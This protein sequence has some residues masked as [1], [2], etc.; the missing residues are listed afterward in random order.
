M[1]SN[2]LSLAAAALAA[3][4]GAPLAAGAAELPSFSCGAP[5]AA[6]TWSSGFSSQPTF[7][8]TVTG[9]SGD[10][11]CFGADFLQVIPRKS[12]EGQKDFLKITLAEAFVDDGE[13]ANAEIKFDHKVFHKLVDIP[14]A[15]GG[16]ETYFDLTQFVFNS[17]GKD[18]FAEVFL[19]LKITTLNKFE[20][21]PTFKWDSESQALQM[22][23]PLQEADAVLTL[24]SAPTAVPEPETWALLTTGL[25]G[26]GALLRRR[27][28]RAW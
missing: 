26:A 1:R 11:G 20:G 15:P 13:K 16:Y 3:S 6:I 8:N 22:F 14:G 25:V 17:D 27:R 12:G 21:V 2:R 19:G 24:T 23:I 5:S 4:A 7:F 18:P 9:A 28:A 10:V